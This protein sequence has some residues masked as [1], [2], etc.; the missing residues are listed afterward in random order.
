MQLSKIG[1][2]QP[3]EMIFTD[4]YTNEAT[5]IKLKIYPKNSKIG[6]QAEHQMIRDARVVTR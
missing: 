6:K 1:Y 2:A 3:K 4:P 5:E